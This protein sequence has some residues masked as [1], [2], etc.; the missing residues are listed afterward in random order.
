MEQQVKQLTTEEVTQLKE[1][2]T[3]YLQV[4]SELGQIKVEQ[5]IIQKQVERLLE[6]ES[7]VSESYLSLQQE[8]ET[9]A[10]VLTEKYGTGNIDIESGTF[11]S[12][13]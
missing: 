12:V 10:K 9:L 5:I 8:E 2:Q 13:S 11:T 6:Y 3:K 1:L 4:T 7:K